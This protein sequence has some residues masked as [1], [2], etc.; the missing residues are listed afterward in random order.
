M[1]FKKSK[2]KT[3]IIAYAIITFLILWLL[4]TNLIFGDNQS[5]V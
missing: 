1:V 3:R 4:P 5:D 2:I